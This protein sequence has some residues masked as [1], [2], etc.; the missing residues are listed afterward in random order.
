MKEI[1]AIVE[2]FDGVERQYENAALATVVNVKGSTYRSSGARMLITQSGRMV[3]TISGGCLEGDVKER[4]GQVMLSG[5]PTVVKYDTTSEDDIVWGL[6]LGCNGVVQVLIERLDPQSKLS[7]L[8]FLAECFRSRQPGVLATVFDVDGRTGVK[9]GD[10]LMLH[11]DNTVTSE[12]EDS[13]LTLAAIADAFAALRDGRSNVKTYQLSAGSVE[14]FI[15]VIQPPT[16][17]VIFGA[18]YDAIPV[19]RFAKELGWHVTVVDSRSAYATKEQFPLAD[20]VILTRPEAAPICVTI[21]H[22]TVAVVMTHN[23]LHDRELLKTLLPSP[24]RYLGILGPKSRTERL[25]QDL[26]EEGIIP[27]QEQLC[28]LYSPIGIDIGADTPE[29]IALAIVAEIRAVVANRSGGFLRNRKGPIHNRVN[30]ENTNYAGSNQ[31]SEI[32]RPN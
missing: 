2:A 23:Y 1:Q 18:G 24:V 9:V 31:L 5:E 20:K 28:R 29:E 19:A 32:A 11:P 6:G 3:G 30:L 4:A 27:T 22:R 16:P 12:I 10:R 17:L 7:P 26:R 25:L 15:E 13:D 14:V 21:D 8:A